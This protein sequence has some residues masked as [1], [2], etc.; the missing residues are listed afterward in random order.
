MKWQLPGRYDCVGPDDEG[1]VTIESCDMVVLDKRDAVA[2]LAAF[3]KAE[4]GTTP[5]T[6]FVALDN[7]RKE[8]EAKVEA[9]KAECLSLDE[10]L[11]EQFADEGIMSVKTDEGTVYLHTRFYCSK[12]KG[13]E[14]SV[15]CAALEANGMGAMVR[16]GYAP[17][18]LTSKMKEMFGE[19][20]VPDVFAGV[21]SENPAECVEALLSLGEITSVRCRKS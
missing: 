17:A 3:E 5:L 8:L 13:V 6:R 12:M 19:D 1:L 11:Q 15:V 2:L 10:V 14:T 4:E 21:E 16:P 9:L 18:T 20:N 7:R